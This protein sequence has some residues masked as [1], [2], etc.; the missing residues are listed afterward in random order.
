[1]SDTGGSARHPKRGTDSKLSKSKWS[2]PPMNTRNTRGVTDAMTVSWKGLEY[3]TK[4]NLMDG[5]ISTSVGIPE[6]HCLSIVSSISSE[7]PRRSGPALTT[8]GSGFPLLSAFPERHCLSIVSNISSEPPRRSGPALTTTGSGFP[9]LSAFPERH[10]LSIVSSISSEPPRRSGPALTTTGRRIT[11]FHFCRHSRSATVSLSSQISALSPSPL[12]T[13]ADYHRERR[14]NVIV[15]AQ[16]VFPLLS[17]FPER[18]CLSIVSSISSE[19][20]RRILKGFAAN[21]FMR[22]DLLKKNLNDWPQEREKKNSQHNTAVATPLCT[23]RRVRRR[24][25]QPP[26]KPSMPRK[27]NLCVD[28]DED[29]I[30]HATGRLDRHQGLASQGSKIR[31]DDVDGVKMCVVSVYEVAHRRPCARYST[32]AVNCKQLVRPRFSLFSSFMKA[33][34]ALPSTLNDSKPEHEAILAKVDADFLRIFEL[35][36]SINLTSDDLGYGKESKRT[37]GPTR[38]A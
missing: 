2:P 38:G 11:T 34:E 19:P 8:T 28:L 15:E 24:I 37:A 32:T 31:H 16:G 26:N 4:G 5:G 6:R 36:D 21:W 33:Y 17:A 22:P 27:W 10:C 13:G 14:N 1:M 30:M 7:P 35:A 29:D 25:A 3:V 9:L 12:R 20:P 18:H 23:A